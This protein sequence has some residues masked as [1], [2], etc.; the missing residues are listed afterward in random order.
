MII[1]HLRQL[2]HHPSYSGAYV[3]MSVEAQ[4]SWF[5]PADIRNYLRTTEGIPPVLV[6]SGD[7]SGHKRPGFPTT[8]S[9]KQ[10]FVRLTQH[11]LSENRLSFANS[12][13]GANV[14]RDQKELIQQMNDYNSEIKRRADGTETERLTGKS[15]VA[16]D[17]LAM[18]L[19][20]G[21]YWF[22]WFRCEEAFRQ[23][24]DIHGWT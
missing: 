16:E 21:C 8:P 7:T 3:L 23:L 20:M 6:L 24:S 12:M 11:V 2:R 13:V 22:H 14:I 18:A 15:E 1:Q 4:H 5:T 9:D 10:Q 17:D 19:Q